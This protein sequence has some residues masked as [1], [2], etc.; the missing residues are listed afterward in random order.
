[1]VLFLLVVVLVLPMPLH[2]FKEGGQNCI[3]CH[4]LTEKDMNPILDKIR[5][6]EAKVLSIQAAPVKGMWEVAVENKGKRFLI[7]VDFAKKFV[8]PG[9]F[10]DYAAGK[11]VTR[12]RAEEIN[13]SKKVDTRSL[14]LDN[15]LVVG[16][17]DAPVRVIVFTDPACSFCARLHKEAKALVAKRPDIAF[18]LKVFA[19]I[20]PDPET[21]KSII[22]AR[23]LSMLED[24]YEKK[25]VP[26][27]EC[28]TRE[29]DENMQFAQASGID[30]APAI[31]FPDGSLHSGYLP[32]DELEKKIDAALKN[33]AQ[34]RAN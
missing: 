22:C 18:Y 25:P 11:D 19:L 31:I 5:M 26:K 27:Q 1:M 20:S 32:A 12:E 16:K 28:A 7:Y 23:S 34:G 30:A 14:P 2:A 6:P 8:S 3:K 13:R 15:A 9:P 10:I 17:A 33:K 21:A 4:S 29:L 24:A